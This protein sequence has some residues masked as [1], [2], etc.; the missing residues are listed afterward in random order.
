MCRGYG[1]TNRNVHMLAALKLVSPLYESSSTSRRP[2]RRVRGCNA[3]FCV[4]GIITE[5]RP[6]TKQAS[7]HHVGVA[8]VH[9]VRGTSGDQGTWDR[10][11]DME[12]SVSILEVEHRESQ[13]R[14][15]R[16]IIVALITT[17]VYA[18]KFSL[19]PTIHFT[20]SRLHSHDHHQA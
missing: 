5:G 12:S 19:T 16:I 9:H 13:K 15:H 2:R 10:D 14:S 6:K 20:I 4:Q 18:P 7:L 11:S 3:V 17:A 1:D 8:S